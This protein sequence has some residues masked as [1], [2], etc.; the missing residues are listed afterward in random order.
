MKRAL[1]LRERMLLKG[2]ALVI[3]VLGGVQ[4]GV[5]PAMAS[6]QDSFAYLRKI[7]IVLSV[8]DVLPSAPAVDGVADLPPLRNRVADSA[9]RAG[10]DIRRLDPQ[11]ASALAVS[12]DDVPF[13]AMIGWLDQL[14]GQD[15]VR[16]L[17]AEIGRRPEPGVV[18]A[19]FLL[20]SR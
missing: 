5:I 15:R 20:E 11:G 14:T 6:R 3:G 9:R 8:L 12:L 18:S 1:S 16:V 19:R 10:L 4:M 2:S 13:A 7:D 17:S